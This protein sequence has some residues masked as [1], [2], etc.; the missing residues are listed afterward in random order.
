MYYIRD[1]CDYS[2]F[3]RDF[4][5]QWVEYRVKEAVAHGGKI[6]LQNSKHVLDKAVSRTA[7]TKFSDFFIRT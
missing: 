7:H 5:E 6:I 1:C 3:D 4:V 2:Q